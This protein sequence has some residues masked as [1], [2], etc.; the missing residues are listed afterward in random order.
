M[1]THNLF[2]SFIV[3]ARGGKNIF[4]Y[5]KNFLTAGSEIFLEDFLKNKYGEI[6]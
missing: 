4:S 3:A 6:R 2:A 5:D 1:T